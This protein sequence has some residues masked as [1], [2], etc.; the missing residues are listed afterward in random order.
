MN[1]RTN[2]LMRRMAFP[3]TNTPVVVNERNIRNLVNEMRNTYL[4]SALFSPNIETTYRR[5]INGQ[6]LLRNFKKE[7]NRKTKRFTPKNRI[8]QKRAV[9]ASFK[10]MNKKLDQKRLEAE[11]LLVMARLKSSGLP[12]DM[13][14]RAVC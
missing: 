13:V 14:K 1:N 7:Y 6:K 9:N 10:N 5:V 3:P 4:A 12:V 8:L 2:S 11:K